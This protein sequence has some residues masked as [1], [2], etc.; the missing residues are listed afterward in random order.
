MASAE[1][2]A[3]L[4]GNGTNRPT[5][6]LNT[7]PTTAAD[8]SSPLR[9]AGT[10]QY[11]GLTNASS[12]QAINM[13]SLIALVGTLQSR[14]LADPAGVGFVMHR[15]TASAIR[16]L[17]STDGQYLWEPSTQAGQPD[18]LLGYPV[19]T[20]D[21]MPTLASDAFA[22]LF[23]NFRRG[24]LLADRVG[25]RITLDQVTNPGYYRYYVR[26]RVGGCVL[27]NDA[28]KALRIAD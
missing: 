21:A 11:V 5:G 25:M 10:I 26:K 19:Y 9:A 12:P 28:V 13:D 24:Y 8:D 6:I 2:T 7:T 18:R 27:N 3:I 4:S 1:T 20:V 15:L 17:R 16:R 22:V 14:Y 23:G